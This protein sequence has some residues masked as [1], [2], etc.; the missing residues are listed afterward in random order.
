MSR[1]D[2]SGQ[3]NARL[4]KESSR[5]S[6]KSSSNRDM[7][8]YSVKDELLWENF[9]DS[10]NHQ[11]TPVGNIRRKTLSDERRYNSNNGHEPHSI[12]YGDLN[13]RYECYSHVNNKTNGTVNV[14]KP[15]ISERYFNNGPVADSRSDQFRLNARV[16]GMDDF[17]KSRCIIV[18]EEGSRVCSSD[19]SDICDKDCANF[20]DGPVFRMEKRQHESDEPRTLRNLVIVPNCVPTRISSNNLTPRDDHGSFST[21]ESHKLNKI[22]RHQTNNNK[23]F[24]ENRQRYSLPDEFIGQS[25]NNRYRE[26]IPFDRGEN[27]R[28]ERCKGH[29]EL[30]KI[31]E[32]TGDL[33]R[34]RSE[35]HEN[36]KYLQEY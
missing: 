23:F 34:K 19:D 7:D 2:A 29:C 18:S 26:T 12:K 14:L 35:Y 30:H 13:Q 10:P 16:E 6:L 17:N 25:D 20:I 9:N 8:T 11:W 32:E 36:E 1:Y 22:E 28:H 15:K 27:S 5:R 33:I 31:R 3:R 24:T 21:F 4:S